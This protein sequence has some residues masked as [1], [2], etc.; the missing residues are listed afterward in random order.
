MEKSYRKDRKENETYVEWIRRKTDIE[1]FTLTIELLTQM[2]RVSRTW[3]LKNFRKD[4][5]FIIIQ[6]SVYYQVESVENWLMNHSTFTVQTRLVNLLDYCTED[7]LRTAEKVTKER[8]HYYA[9]RAI[10]NRIKAKHIVGFMPGKLLK[11][12]GLPAIEVLYYNRP[13]MKEVR[14]KPFN[15]LWKEK[16]FAKDAGTIGSDFRH[17]FTEQFYREAF[18]LGYCKVTIGSR[19]TFL[20]PVKRPG[21][22]F[23]EWT[24]PA[25]TKNINEDKILPLSFDDF[26]DS[27]VYHR[28]QFARPKQANQDLR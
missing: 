25:V 14:V 20:I 8:H 5:N 23:V 2:L 21:S 3:I 6:G 19:K 10:N 12:L 9:V 1:H 17:K 4:C 11:E 22:Y 15:Y 13:A 28:D 18:M 27:R 7:D 24:I 16:I 26:L